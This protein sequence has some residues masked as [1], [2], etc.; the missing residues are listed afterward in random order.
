MRCYAR[1]LLLRVLTEAPF[2]TSAQKEP[3]HDVIRWRLANC[4]T[5]RAPVHAC[6]V[7][8][9]AAAAAAADGV[10]SDARCCMLREMWAVVALRVAS[11]ISIVVRDARSGSPEDPLSSPLQRLVVVVCCRCKT[12]AGRR[13]HRRRRVVMT[14]SMTSPPSGADMSSTTPSSPSSGNVSSAGFEVSQSVG[15]SGVS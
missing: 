4:W 7:P 2:K 15:H 9:A 10:Y 5:W 12:P 3:S 11:T 13:R 6:D 14:S 8:P 1:M